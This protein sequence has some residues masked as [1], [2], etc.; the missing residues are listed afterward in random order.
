MTEFICI[1][2]QRHLYIYIYSIFSR[3]KALFYMKAPCNHCTA[4]LISLDNLAKK[5]KEQQI[6][7]PICLLFLNRWLPAPPTK[8]WPGWE[9]IC[10][11]IGG[12]TC[13]LGW[14]TQTE[15]TCGPVRQG[16]WGLGSPPVL[17]QPR[18]TTGELDATGRRRPQKGCR[19]DSERKALWH[20]WNIAQNNYNKLL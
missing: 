15:I 17:S 6:E 10:P 9:R 1:I 2:L 11:Y 8:T 12:N 20:K 16:A 4:L 5:Q 14:F 18:L 3:A 19:R 13:L 7:F